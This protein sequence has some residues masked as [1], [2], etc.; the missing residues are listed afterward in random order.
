MTDL[1][2][3]GCAPDLQGVLS[4]DTP[5]L[6]SKDADKRRDKRATHLQL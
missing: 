6:S 4:R 2:T 1:T 3:S 5:L